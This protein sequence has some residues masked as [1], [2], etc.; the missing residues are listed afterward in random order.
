MKKASSP[1]TASVSPG[2]NACDVP[3]TAGLDGQILCMDFQIL[4]DHYQRHH[5][6][7]SVVVAQYRGRR[8]QLRQD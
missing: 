6:R 2:P 3:P 8:Y 1:A 7:W 4:V 5:L